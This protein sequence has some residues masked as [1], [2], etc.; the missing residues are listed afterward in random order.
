MLCPAGVELRK[1]R[2]EIH[3]EGWSA[4]ASVGIYSPLAV[5]RE[6]VDKAV[7]A[8]EAQDELVTHVASCTDCE[9]QRLLD[10]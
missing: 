9:K 1:R 7:M 4:L 10:D 6:A 5:K 3:L 8:Q 2:D